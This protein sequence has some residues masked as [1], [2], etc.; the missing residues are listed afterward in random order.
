MHK[1]PGQLEILAERGRWAQ[2]P[3]RSGVL[4]T[5]H[6]SALLRGDADDRERGF[7]RWVAD[8]G[9]ATSALTTA[10]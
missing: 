4:V 1:T 6:P 3:D 8:L 2:R 9:M 5:L 7:E 10:P